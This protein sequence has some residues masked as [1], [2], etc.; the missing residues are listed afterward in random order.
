MLQ[1]ARKVYDTILGSLPSMP[2]A[3][4]RHAPP[5]V[6]A[7]A[8]AELLHSQGDS[9]ARAIHV[10]A[11]LGTGGTYARYKAPGGAAGASGLLSPDR[12]A[13]AHLFEDHY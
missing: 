3:Y 13:A 8:C 11:R 10:L 1:A 5:L 12:S 7:Y 6:L 2:Q 9:A 4:V